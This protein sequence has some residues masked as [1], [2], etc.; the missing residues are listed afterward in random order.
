M[1]IWSIAKTTFGDAM[2][3]KVVQIFLVVAMG[4]II[5]SLSFSQALSFSRQEGSATDIMLVKSFGL[6]LMA[7]AGWLISLVMGVSLIPQEIERRTIYTILSKPVKRFEFIIGKYLGAMLT[8]AVCVGLMGVVFFGVVIAKAHGADVSSATQTSG[9]TNVGSHGADIW[10]WNM[11]WGVV[12]IYLQFM[13]L[14][15]VVI[16]FSVF[17][18]PTV[19]F[20]MGLGVYIVGVMASLTETL[21]TTQDGNMIL[22]WFYTIIHWCIPNFDKF[23]VTNTLLHPEAHIT[24]VANYTGKVA[25]YGLTYT[26]VMML[27]A[28]IIFEKKEV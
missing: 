20:F 19:N 2:R 1:I 24:N 7:L 10:D 16:L 23:N 8:L 3:K 4:L 22:K 17:F 12:M 25:L 15:A 28:V 26:L 11:L 18:T 21:A 14:S 9:I 6:G 27:L 5:I 13:V